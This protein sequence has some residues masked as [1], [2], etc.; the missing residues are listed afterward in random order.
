MSDYVTAGDI[1]FTLSGGSANTDPNSSLGGSPSAYEITGSVNNLFDDVTADEAE[2]GHTG[3][4]CF[5][6]F[7]NSELHT[8][9]DTELYIETEVE[10]GATVELGLRTSN[11]VQKITIENTASGGTLTI[12]YEDDSAVINY[13]ADGDTWAQ[14]FETGI[15]TLDGISEVSVEFGETVDSFIFFVTFNGEEAGRSF[16]LLEVVA[17]GLTSS[18]DVTISR[19]AAGSPIN[20]IP[21][22]IA[23]ETSP[24]VGVDFT[25]STEEEPLTIGDLRPGDGVPVWVRRT[26]A[27][28]SDPLPDDGFTLRLRG[29][30]FV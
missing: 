13:D 24:P 1:V 6:V 3:H 23:T 8:L 5:Y 17:N 28:G 22:A 7:N 10:D 27:V 2:D 30:P 29:K 12:G 14:N 20:S 25:D 18:P 26:V 19:V 21:S 11:E 4:R 15:M 16:D 9:Y